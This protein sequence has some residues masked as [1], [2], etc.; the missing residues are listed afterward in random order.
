VSLHDLLATSFVQHAFYAVTAVAIAAGAV[1]YFV[2]LRRQAFA[3][4][5][6]GHV[7]SLGPPA[8]CC[9]VSHRSWDCSCSVSEPGCSSGRGGVARRP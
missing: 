4:H 3:A 1:G 2:V 5:A 6:I 8:R 9:S 7:G